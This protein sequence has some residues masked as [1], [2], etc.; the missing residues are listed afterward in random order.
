M[1]SPLAREFVYFQKIGSAC[2]FM[3]LGT[4]VSPHLLCHLP[5]SHLNSPPTRATHPITE[6]CAIYSAKFDK[7]YYKYW[8]D[9]GAHAAMSFGVASRVCNF[10]AQALGKTYTNSE[11]HRIPW[12]RTSA[13]ERSS[14]YISQ[15]DSLS[16]A[17]GLRIFS[18]RSPYT[19]SL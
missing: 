16:A 17:V 2:L 11:V 14:F 4:A 3:K 15:C 13:H 6:Y 18:R 5:R 1:K 19:G 9:G 10:D 8:C 12:E 7:Y